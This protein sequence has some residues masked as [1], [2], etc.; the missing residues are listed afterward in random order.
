MF[1]YLP[2]ETITMNGTKIE[3]FS[4]VCSLGVPFGLFCVSL[5]EVINYDFNFDILNYFEF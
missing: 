5:L 3:G 1:V 4:Q 2:D